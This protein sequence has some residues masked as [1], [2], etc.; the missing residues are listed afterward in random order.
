MSKRTRKSEHEAFQELLEKQRDELN[1]RIEQRRQEIVIEQEPDDEVGLALRN[2]STGMAIANIE[3]ELR[4]LGEIELSLRR[5]ETG[6]YGICG[7]CGERIPVARL[8]AIPWTRCCV[9]CAGG[10]VR[11]NAQSGRM[12][13]PNFLSVQH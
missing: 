9:E 13:A 2:S 8:R 12:L 7:V 3:R 4:T 6:E 11:R 10:G 1:R 5:I